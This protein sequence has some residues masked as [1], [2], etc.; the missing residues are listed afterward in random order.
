MLSRREYEIL[1]ALTQG[2]SNREIAIRFT[3]SENI[4]KFHLRNIYE[5][6]GVTNRTQASLH[7]ALSDE[8]K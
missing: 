4:V 8:N 6:T 5:K 3:I 2:I 1:E 7:H